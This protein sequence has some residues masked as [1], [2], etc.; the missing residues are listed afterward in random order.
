V[1][2]L[3]ILGTPDLRRD[4]GER[5]SPVLARPKLFALLTYLA[6]ARPQGLHRRDTLVAMFWPE[7]AT[8]Q[9]RGALR[10]ALFHLRRALGTHALVGRGDAEIGLAEGVL[11][12]D[13]VAFEAAA[14]AAPADALALYA[15]DLLPGFFIEDAP[16]FESWLEDERQR[17]ARLA[18]DTFARHVAGLE[19]AGRTES[20]IEWAQRALALAPAGEATLQRLLRLLEQ[21]GDGV[22]AIQTYEQFRDRLERMYELTPS[23]ETSALVA[24]IRARHQAQYEAQHAA[25]HA[26]QDAAQDAAQHAAQDAAQDAVPHELQ[27]GNAPAPL[28]APLAALLDLAPAVTGEGVEPGPPP[29]E[30]RRPARTRF[31]AGRLLSVGAFVMLALAVALV[32]AVRSTN[33]PALLAI[34][35]IRDFAGSAAPLPVEV[36]PHLLATNLARGA[37]V[38]VI[39]SSWL[40]EL[41]RGADAPGPAA[42]VYM[43]ARQAGADQLLEGA[44]YLE[45]EGIYRLDLRRVRLRDGKVLGSYTVRAADA[46]ALV[47]GATEAIQREWRG[48][49]AELHVADV[50]TGSVDAY[51]LYARGLRL[52][53]QDGNA[54]QATTFFHAALEEDSTF[55]MAAYYTFVAGAGDWSAKEY[56]ERALR[57]SDR[58]TDRERLLI[59]WAWAQW[60]DEP[61]A[62][63]YADTLVRRFP[64]EPA[65]HYALGSA[66]FQSGDFVGA[67]ARLSHVI[68][69]DSVA[70][71]RQRSR[72]HACDALHILTMTHLATDSSDAAIRLAVWWVERT[73]L[74]LQALGALATALEIGGRFDEARAVWERIARRDP[75]SAAGTPATSLIALRQGDF[76]AADQLLLGRTLTPGA[77]A[78]QAMWY[79]V[80]SLRYQGRL[81]DALNLA[82]RLRDVA[83]LERAAAQGGRAESPPVEAIPHATVLSDLGRHREAAAIFDSLALQVLDGAADVALRG[84]DARNRAWRLTLAASAHAAAGDTTRLA[85]YADRVQRLGARSLYGRDQRLHHHVRALLLRAR[86]DTREAERAFRAAIHSPTF[87]YTRTNVELARLLIEQRR[88]AEAVPLLRAALRGSLEAANLYVTHPELH[89]LL[90]DALRQ[91]GRP[92]SAAAHYRH[93]LHA[94]QQADPQYHARRTELEQ[95][96]GTLQR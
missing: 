12:C 86:G 54:S 16:A 62:L 87:G 66:L 42:A 6:L 50:T 8:S 65:G 92:D 73:P 57:L 89:A 82:L 60:R 18:Q 33:G 11:W 20:A 34:G 71:A 75:A 90:G 51:R 80:L 5:L 52:L 17:L 72:C 58:L 32:L 7:S 67:A 81:H 53:Y 36:L 85:A 24:R 35:E 93:V 30:E 31:H 84:H 48:A 69:L 70:L 22:A 10:K 68:A 49:R 25:Q 41:S 37:G 46:F 79:G 77:A 88:A 3:R 74:S 44:L 38:H 39:S 78:P 43:A 47:D 14:R 9:A 27:A 1:I 21:R 63:A 83:M 55:A 56:L 76:A 61:S 23:A 59:R 13:A 96:L 2:E 28:A 64:A 45:D 95:A 29:R 91:A 19:A 4:A 94:W 26:A 40:L 15:G